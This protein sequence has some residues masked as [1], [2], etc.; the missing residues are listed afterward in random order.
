MWFFKSN[1]RNQAY[2]EASLAK[3]ALGMPFLMHSHGKRPMGMP[4]LD[5]SHGRMAL[6]MLL[7]EHSHQN[8]LQAIRW[9]CYFFSIPID[10]CSECYLFSIPIHKL[11]LNSKGLH[12]FQWEFIKIQ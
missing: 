1:S 10:N 4:Y 3:L 8:V 5:D 6:G 12:E 7:F 11:K 9:E 2:Y